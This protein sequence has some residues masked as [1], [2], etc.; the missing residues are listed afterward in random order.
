METLN[1]VT[2]RIHDEL[3]CITC[4][5][6]LHKVGNA[7]LL[8]G[9]GWGAGRA[10]PALGQAADGEGV[11][12]LPALLAQPQRVQTGQRSVAQP[13]EFLARHQSR[14]ALVLGVGEVVKILYSPVSVVAAADNENGFCVRAAF[15]IG[16]GGVS[17]ALWGTPAT[18][19]VINIATAGLTF[20]FQL[21][22]L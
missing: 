14:R 15:Y 13:P 10:R 3:Y 1:T 22:L 21:V 19:K 7:V 9:E 8:R 16:A 18:Q 2:S 11:G 20:K 5:V 12:A 4:R 6:E 17:T